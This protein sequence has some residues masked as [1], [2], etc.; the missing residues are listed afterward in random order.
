MLVD[1]VTSEEREVDVCIEHEVAG[2]RVLVCVECRDHARVADVTWVEQMRSKHA[3][4]PTSHLALVSRA[5]FSKAARSKARGYGIELLTPEEA[6]AS[7]L[8]RLIGSSGRLWLHAYWL[9]VERVVV[10]VSGAGKPET[11]AAHPTTLVYLGDGAEL[12]QMD[13]VATFMVR[14]ETVGDQLAANAKPD[15]TWFEVLWERPAD[16]ASCPL[17]LRKVN[18]TILRPIEAISV[19]GP[20]EV[21]AGDFRVSRSTIGGVHVAWGSVTL[22]DRRTLMVATEDRTGKQQFSVSVSGSKPKL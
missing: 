18:S 22:G 4:L 14:N 16:L 7:Q 10:R 15:H 12:A 11:V 20:C 9:T 3:D 21:R 13:V 2:H 19:S 5:G 17:C 8:D 6:A 1:R